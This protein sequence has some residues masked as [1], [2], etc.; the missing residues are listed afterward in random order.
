M[1][2]GEEEVAA[3]LQENRLRRQRG[4]PAHWHAATPLVGSERGVPAF[5]HCRSSSRVLRKPRSGDAAAA[6][7]DGRSGCIPA[8]F[9]R[10][11]RPKVRSDSAGCNP[12]AAAAAV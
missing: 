4:I 5:F 3:L 11:L 9:Q 1:E 7:E 6:A 2:E 12:V 10:E 8:H